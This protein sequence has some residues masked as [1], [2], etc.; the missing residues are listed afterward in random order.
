M[1]HSP[2]WSQNQIKKAAVLGSGLG[3]MMGVAE[4]LTLSFSSQLYLTTV[5]SFTLFALC[6]YIGGLTG[7]L[8]GALS[9]YI[10]QRFVETMI[11]V[12]PVWHWR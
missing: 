7:A 6:I 5:E 12:V 4:A 11:W 3:L 9:G 10:S 2:P 8:T 1:M